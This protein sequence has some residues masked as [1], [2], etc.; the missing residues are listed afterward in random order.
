MNEYDTPCGE[1]KIE[2]ANYSNEL[3]D[4]ENNI[5]DINEYIIRKESKIIYKNILFDDMKIPFHLTLKKELNNGIN[6]IEIINC[7]FEKD[8][9]IN[10]EFIS[11]SLK[12][13]CFEEKFYINNQYN[14]PDK[15]IKIGSLNIQDTKFNANFKLHNSEIKNFVL[16]DTDF[17]KNAD[18]FKTKFLTTKDIVFHT[19]NFR[20]LALFGETVFSEY[21]IFKYVTFQGYSHFREAVFKKGLNLEYANIEKEMNFFGIK[22]LDKKKSIENTNQETYRIVKYQLQKVGNIIDSNKYHTLELEKKRK[23][24]CNFCDNKNRSSLDCLVL[25]I[26]KIS[27]NYST[28]WF[29]SLLWILVVGLIFNLYLTNEF[30]SINLFKYISLLTSKEDF[31][32]NYILFV[33]NKV[34]LGYLYYQFVTAIRKDTRK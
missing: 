12:N 7:V 20:A 23:K 17:E 13:C 18:F 19:I 15:V 22:E 29:L 14:N 2:L 30:L 3:L 25:N 6:D 24:V 8:V 21:L 11:L 33:L 27:S 31:S 34:I 26:H 10:K 9:L 1:K 28:N 16:K 5:F 4:S 32:S